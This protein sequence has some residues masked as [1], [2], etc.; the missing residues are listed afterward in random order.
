M[1]FLKPVSGASAPTARNAISYQSGACH[2]PHPIPRHDRARG[3][4]FAG[5]LELSHPAGRSAEGRWDFWAENARSRFGVSE[6]ERSP[7]GWA[8][9]AKNRGTIVRSHRIALANPV[10]A[11]IAA[12]SAPIRDAWKL[13]Y[14]AAAPHSSLAVAGPTCAAAVSGRIWQAH[15]ALSERLDVS[16]RTYR[17]G[18]RACPENQRTDAQGSR[19]S[20]RAEQASDCRIDRRTSR[21]PEVQGFCDFASAESRYQDL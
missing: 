4:R 10:H 9:R 7:G 21:D 16:T 19:R 6:S 5:R 8:G 15:I 11:A 12:P 18:P 17:S 14:Q 20:L 13:R 3:S 1:R 2:E